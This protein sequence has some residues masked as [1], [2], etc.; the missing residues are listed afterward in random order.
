MK[1]H[2]T[3]GLKKINSC[4]LPLQTQQTAKNICEREGK[5][6]RIL[7]RKWR[8]QENKNPNRQSFKTKA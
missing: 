3:S 1:I 8:N 7:Q 6:Q 2:S 4:Y 5:L